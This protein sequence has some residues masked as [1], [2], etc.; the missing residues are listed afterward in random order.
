M[1]EQKY[2]IIKKVTIVKDSNDKS[3]GYG[4]IE[5]DSKDDFITAY[6]QANNRKIDGRR[7]LVDYERGNSCN[8]IIF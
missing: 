3:M 7:V 1:I 8:Y 6:K 2:G 4:F 5:F